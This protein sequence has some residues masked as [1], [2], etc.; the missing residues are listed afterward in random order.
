MTHQDEA[1]KL[2]VKVVSDYLDAMPPETRNEFFAAVKH[3]WLIRL[4]KA[5]DGVSKF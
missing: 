4:P 2:L 1:F 3:E 5:E